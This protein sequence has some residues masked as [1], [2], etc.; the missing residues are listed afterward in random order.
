MLATLSTMLGE[1][2]EPSDYGEMES[3]YFPKHVVELQ[4][5]LGRLDALNFGVRYGDDDEPA[6][7]PLPH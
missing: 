4:Y 2:F 1:S 7:P 6:W 3:Y 5:R